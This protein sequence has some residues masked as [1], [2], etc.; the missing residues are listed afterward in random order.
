MIWARLATKHLSRPNPPFCHWKNSISQ[1]KDGGGLFSLK[2]FVCSHV[3]WPNFPQVLPSEDPNLG[4]SGCPQTHSDRFWK[5]ASREQTAWIG[6]N[7]V[8]CRRTWLVD[9]KPV[10]NLT[11]APT[12][13]ISI[14][15]S[16]HCDT[17]EVLLAKRK[18]QRAREQV[19][20]DAIAPQGHRSEIHVYFKPSSSKWMPTTLCIY[21][22]SECSCLYCASF[23]RR[24]SKRDRSRSKECWGRDTLSRMWM[25]Q[26]V[27]TRIPKLLSFWTP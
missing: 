3:K 13:A 4:S 2:L 16:A 23:R 6:C 27:W 17:C 7:I 9:I 11:C 1:E 8:Q 18:L 24:L 10:Q 19:W 5:L 12:W 26:C 21:N 22:I 15:S 14:H 25:K 20:I